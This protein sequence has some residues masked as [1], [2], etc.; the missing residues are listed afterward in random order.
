MDGGKQGRPEL[1]TAGSRADLSYGWRE[2]CGEMYRIGGR[3]LWAG[4]KAG[5]FSELM[6][7]KLAFACQSVLHGFRQAAEIVAL[8]RMLVSFGRRACMS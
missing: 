3:Q 8:K 1:W 7:G 2:G 6:R 4:Q 5:G